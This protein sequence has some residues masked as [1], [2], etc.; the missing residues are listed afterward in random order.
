MKKIKYERIKNTFTT[1]L[2]NLIDADFFHPKPK[3]CSDEFCKKVVK[4]FFPINAY[5]L[6][7]TR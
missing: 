2:M 5:D 7:E 3:Y 6:K 4:T 1:I